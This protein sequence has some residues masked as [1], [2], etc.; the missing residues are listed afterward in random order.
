MELGIF[1]DHVLEAAKQ[2]N[3]TIIEV[4]QHAASNG[5]KNL[6]IDSAYWMQHDREIDQLLMQSGMTIHSTFAHAD[7]AHDH[8]MEKAESVIR[9]AADH[10]VEHVLL[11]PGFVKEGEERQVIIERIAKHLG[12]LVQTANRQSVICSLEDFDH[13]DATF[14]TWSEL[15][16][17]A[18]EV[19]GLAITFDT[20]NFAYFGQD[21]LTALD[22]LLVYVKSVHCKDRSFT[23]LRG[24]EGLGCPDGRRLFPC[25]VGEGHIP[26]EP[27][28]RK[29][30][31]SGYDGNLTIEHY[32]CN[33]QY[34]AM[35]DSAA[36]L[37][38]LLHM[39]KGED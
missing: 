2:E 31:A 32:D 4:L 35:A 6:T 12:E 3:C 21:A 13:V 36:Y 27:M 30:V 23:Q 17:Y 28:M 19:A 9:F 29:L 1:F 5:I 11:I 7:L 18:S 20:G 33:H 25:A 8:E 38:N 15:K 16:H 26:F 39:L 10:G 37:N 24:E 22:E 34:Q 14:G